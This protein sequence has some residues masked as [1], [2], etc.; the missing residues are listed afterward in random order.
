MLRGFGRRLRALAIMITLLLTANAVASPFWVVY[1]VEQIGLTSAEWGLILLAETGVRNLAF[2]PAG[3]L[4]DRHGRSKAMATSLVL[5]LVAVPLFPFA[6]GF[7]HVLAI[8]LGVAL[9]NA[10][11]SPAC[12]A[13]MADLV[14]RE[15]RGRVMAALGRGTV[16][17][18]PAAGGTGGPGVGFVVT[19]PLMVASLAGGYLYALK[20]RPS[21]GRSWRWPRSP[22]WRCSPATS[23]IQRTR[24]YREMPAASTIAR[25][26][27]PDSHHERCP[28]L[29]VCNA[30]R[31][32]TSARAV[33]CPSAGHLAALP[34]APAFW[35]LKTVTTNPGS[36]RRR[37]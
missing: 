15:S 25:S 27:S 28:P 29:S 30:P 33:R 35:R 5:T 21:P 36:S 34:S 14:P 12:S 2:I 13:L 20:M 24:M 26:G 22:R 31:S 18:G 6:T 17:L 16:M 19:V 23:A 7:A 9:A 37:I 4:V 11:F 8:R 32:G 10:F 3:M 1:A